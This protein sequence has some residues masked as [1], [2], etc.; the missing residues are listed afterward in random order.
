MM[1]MTPARVRQFQSP[2]FQDAQALPVISTSSTERRGFSLIEML[3]VISVIT[4]LISLLLPALGKSREQ[5]RRTICAANSRGQV[6]ACDAYSVDNSGYFPPSQ[7]KT[8]SMWCYAFDIRGNFGASGPKGVGT[9]LERGYFNY[10]PKAFHCPSLDTSSASPYGTV[11]H[12]MDVNTPNWW[13]SVGASYWNDPAYASK[14]ITIGYTYRAP[15][16]WLSNPTERYIRVSSTP[17]KT[18]M[19]ADILDIRFGRRYTH[20]Q[21][22][23]FTRIDGSGH[24]FA[25]PAAELEQIVLDA[26]RVAVDGINTSLTDELVFKFLEEGN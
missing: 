14:R 20:I 18:V 24:W 23:N 16:W 8:G 7:N 10:E 9:T 11:Y 1:S 6:Q 21:G 2:D 25:D 17:G 3:V 26:G 5:T 12:S 13:N 4:L 19:N 22:Y 15:S